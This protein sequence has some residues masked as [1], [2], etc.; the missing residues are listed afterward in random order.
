[1]YG[2]G[3]SAKSWKGSKKYDYGSARA[4]YD[5]AA[6]SAGATGSRSFVTKRDAD[7]S[8]VDPLGK[9]ISSE[10]TDPIIIGIDVTGSMSSWPAEIFDR[11]PLLYQTL[12]KYRPDAEFS[13]CAIGDAYCDNYPLQVNAF[14]KDINELEASI[15]ALGAEGG[16]GGQTSETY[17]LFGNFMLEHCNTPK[18][19]SPFLLIYGDEKFYDT[20]NPDQVKHFI[21]DDMQ[22]ALNSKDMWGQLMQKFNVYFLQKSYG[23][24][25][26]STTKEVKHHWE[27]SLG[28]QRVL[29]VPNAER[30]VDI[31]MGLI[32]RQWGQYGDFSKSLD[33]RHDDSGLKASVH[34]SLRHVDGDPS[35]N[36][37]VSRRSKESKLTKSLL[38]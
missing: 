27:K 24:G 16:G 15:K 25:E 2:W 32:A 7:M 28:S 36:S 29:D 21:G 1:M 8:L 10:S 6:A 19:T 30:A 23:Y 12:A 37:V 5:K 14:S 34:K 18:A 13:F 22:D 3:G 20:V 11:L 9:I 26:S 31:G 33:A 38:D 35:V 17:E 4:R